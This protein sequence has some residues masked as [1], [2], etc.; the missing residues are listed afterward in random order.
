MKSLKSLWE[1]NTA[2][3]CFV[4]SL[5]L[6]ALDLSLVG[7]LSCFQEED[8]RDSRRQREAGRGRQERRR[9]PGLGLFLVPPLRLAEQQQNKQS[10]WGMGEKEVD[11]N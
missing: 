4:P 10:Q 8:L 5:W 11:R 9:R 2:R 6:V 1:V 3:V 7:L